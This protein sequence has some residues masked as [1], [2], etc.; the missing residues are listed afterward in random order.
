MS[1]PLSP[2]EAQISGT[3]IWHDNVRNSKME[4][5]PLDKHS[6]KMAK[7]ENHI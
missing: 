4:K 7:K 3:F 5:K 6:D 2:V 1:S